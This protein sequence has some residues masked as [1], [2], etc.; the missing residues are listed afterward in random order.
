MTD[1]TPQAIVD[2][3]LA[4]F[5][6]PAVGTTREAVQ[7]LVAELVK[8]ALL[9]EMQGEVPGEP[10]ASVAAQAGAERQP[11]AAPTLERFT[12]LQSLLLL[13]PIHDVDDSGWPRQ[14]T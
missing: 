14:P 13:D 5:E 7:A 3:L 8:D 6:A 2:A 11:W 1:R 12:D 9:V 10:P 4:R